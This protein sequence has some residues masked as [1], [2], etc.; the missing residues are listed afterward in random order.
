MPGTH[1]SGAYN[2]DWSRPIYGKS[3][4]LYWVSKALQFIPIINS[5]VSKWVLTQEHD[6]Y[7]QLKQGSRMLDLRVS[8][9][10][11]DKKFYITHT[12]TCCTLDK[13]LSDIRRFASEHPTEIV[14]VNMEP[15]HEHR[16]VTNGKEAELKVEIDKLFGER[17]VTHSKH[18]PSYNVSLDEAKQTGQNCLISWNGV[19]EMRGVAHNVL[20]EVWN[21]ASS[22]SK[23]IEKLTRCPEIRSDDAKQKGRYFSAAV[24]PDVDSI[25]QDLQEMFYSGKAI[26]NRE[27]KYLCL[28]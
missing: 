22:V 3:N 15:D 12:F 20:S 11:E 28:L 13:A 16:A 9:N 7:T 23:K 26:G 21:A 24:T 25:K 4:L 19:R 8:Y 17:M 27:H 18:K 2:V 10:P 5:V 1:D 14:V 6:I